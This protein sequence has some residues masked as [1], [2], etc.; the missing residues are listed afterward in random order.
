MLE[1]ETTDNKIIALSIKMAYEILWT[2]PDVEFGLKIPF[3]MQ[4]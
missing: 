4:A 2:S 3:N 1:L